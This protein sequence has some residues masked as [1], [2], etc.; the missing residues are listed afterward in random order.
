MELH[1]EAVDPLDLLQSCARTVAPLAQASQLHLEVNLP[2]EL[3]LI[4]VD[5]N[6]VRPGGA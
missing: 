4:D 2:P 6:R 3:P 5:P 1:R